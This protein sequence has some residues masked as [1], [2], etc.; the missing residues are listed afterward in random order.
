[1]FL[2]SNFVTAVEHLEKHAAPLVAWKAWAAL[3]RAL[4]AKGDAAAVSKAYE[5]S[6]EIIMGFI[7][8]RIMK[9]VKPD[10]F[11]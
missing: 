1:M 4:R 3:A 2:I 6:A 8:T 10:Q 9:P 5:R 11:W 7:R